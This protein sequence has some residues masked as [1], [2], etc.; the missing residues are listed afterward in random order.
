MLDKFKQLGELNKMRAQAVKIQK[1]LKK[2]KIEVVENGI[3]VV[4]SGWDKR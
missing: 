1:E 2:E 4:V 3:K